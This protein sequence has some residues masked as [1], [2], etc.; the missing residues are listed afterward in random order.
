MSEFALPLW[1]AGIVAVVGLPVAWLTLSARNRPER[2]DGP[3][4][5]GAATLTVVIGLFF[6]VYSEAAGAPTLLGGGILALVGVG[7][8]T[9]V[10]AWLP[11]PEGAESGH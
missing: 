7:S 1:M 6:L 8:L 4:V 10:I 11:E 5:V 9:G 3:T 2:L